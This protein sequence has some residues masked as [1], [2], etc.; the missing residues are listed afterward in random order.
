[1]WCENAAK[2]SPATIFV[3]AP[4]TTGDRLRELA[5]A[6]SGAAATPN[7]LGLLLPMSCENARSYRR[8]AC[9]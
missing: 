5:A 6:G 8:T 1:L 4:I 3:A 7:M 9:S 2:C